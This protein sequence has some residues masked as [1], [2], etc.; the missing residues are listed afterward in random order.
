MS[1]A[2]PSG[3]GGANANEPHCYLVAQPLVRGNLVFEHVQR[4]VLVI[5]RGAVS[6]PL[7]P[8]YMITSKPFYK[9]LCGRREF[10]HLTLEPLPLAFYFDT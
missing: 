3:G 9:S 4:R 8:H 6:P 7:D 5:Q 1:S 2:E 10:E